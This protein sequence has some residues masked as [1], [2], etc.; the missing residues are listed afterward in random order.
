M[1]LYRETICVIS[2]LRLVP[3]LVGERASMLHARSR[4]MVIRPMR[5]KQL[6]QALR[7]SAR[8]CSTIVFFLGFRARALLSAASACSARSLSIVFSASDETSWLLN[9]WMTFVVEESIGRASVDCT[10][11]LSFFSLK[12]MRADSVG[13]R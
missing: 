5:F 8:I 12:A 7:C 6:A 11:L 3:A 9:D 13:Y 10:T 4:Q 2:L 1:S